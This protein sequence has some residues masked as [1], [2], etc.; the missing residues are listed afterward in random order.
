MVIEEQQEAV[1][2]EETVLE[3]LIEN[4]IDDAE[5]ESEE[6]VDFITAF[7]DLLVE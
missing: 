3:D 4:V 7:A 6:E 5:D 2:I 1:E